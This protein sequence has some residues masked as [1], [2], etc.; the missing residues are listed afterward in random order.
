MKFD[1]TEFLLEHNIVE[2]SIS[3]IADKVYID[4]G[5]DFSIDNSVGVVII[6]DDDIDKIYIENAYIRERSSIIGITYE[7]YH[8]VYEFDNKTLKRIF[9]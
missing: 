3:E 2:F 9:T 7:S 5:N 6:Y 8:I 1:I 4:W